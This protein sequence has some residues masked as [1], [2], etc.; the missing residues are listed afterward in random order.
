MRVCKLLL[1]FHNGKQAGVLDVDAMKLKTEDPE[2]RAIFAR[3]QKDG[4]VMMT[5]APAKAGVNRD[6]VE[7]VPVNQRTLGELGCELLSHGYQL[8]I[9]GNPKKGRK[10][11]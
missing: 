3:L 5:A 1:I 2:L 9:A 4:M 11:Q 6:G 10:Q 8:G 7:I